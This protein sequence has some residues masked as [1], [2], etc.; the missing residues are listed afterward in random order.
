MALDHTTCVILDPWSY[1]VAPP[2]CRSFT[3]PGSAFPVSVRLSFNIAGQFRPGQDRF[4]YPHIAPSRKNKIC[5]WFSSSICSELYGL[6]TWIKYKLFVYDFFYSHSMYNLLIC[7]VTWF[8]ESRSD[9]HIRSDQRF[10]DHQIFA[11][12]SWSDKQY[13]ENIE[14]CA[15]ASKQIGAGGQKQFYVC[16]FTLYTFH[17]LAQSLFESQ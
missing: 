10:V 11:N 7:H 4:I 8:N 15:I 3:G 9:Q 16:T 2:S 5:I 12:F 1:I 17:E 14:D 13:K 6:V